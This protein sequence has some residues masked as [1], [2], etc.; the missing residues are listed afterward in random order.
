[1]LIN[2]LKLLNPKLE[3]EAEFEKIAETE[4]QGDQ[5]FNY[6]NLIGITTKSYSTTEE[7]NAAEIDDESYC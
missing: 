2:I 1:M 6:L 7:E 4:E 3:V 5:Y